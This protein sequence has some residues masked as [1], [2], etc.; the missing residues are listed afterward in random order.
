MNKARLIEQAASHVTKEFTD[1]GKLIEAG[2][3]AFH[4]LVVPKDAPVSKSGGFAFSCRYAATGPT[5]TCV[6]P[7]G[8]SMILKRRSV[9]VADEI[10]RTIEA[11]RLQ[12]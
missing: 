12:F 11:A 5:L 3:A 2:W 9:S 6:A 8:K 7:G 4:H 10:L 1:R